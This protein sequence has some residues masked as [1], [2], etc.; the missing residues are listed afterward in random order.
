[1][2]KLLT[3]SV[4]LFLAAVT[5]LPAH[6]AP[7]SDLFSGGDLTQDKVI[8]ASTEPYVISKPI[9]V[10]KDV[11][12]TIEAGATLISN[13]PVTFEVAGNVRLIGTAENPV[14]IELGNNESIKSIGEYSS[15]IFE[16]V[17]LL[18]GQ[19]LQLARSAVSITDSEIAG[20]TGCGANSVTLGAGSKF[21]RNAFYRA[22]PFD[23]EANFGLFGPTGFGGDL[24][25]GTANIIQN[26]FVGD[27]NQGCWVNV[28]SLWKDSINLRGNEFRGVGTCAIGLGFFPT[29]VT[30]EN[31]FWGDYK[32]EKVKA[33]V[34]GSVGDFFTAP[35]IQLNS[36]APT[37]DPAAPAESILKAKLDSTPSFLSSRTAY[38]SDSRF[39]ELT[40]KFQPGALSE[41]LKNFEVGLFAL[42]AQGLDPNLDSS[43][44]PV[45]TLVTIPASE[46]MLTSE[47]LSGAASQA[48]FAKSE[49][50]AVRVR[51]NFSGWS[52]SWS[53]LVAIQASRLVSHAQ[54]ATELVQ[55]VETA[56]SL[57]YFDEAAVAVN[58][59][60]S[61][62]AKEELQARLEK[63]KSSAQAAALAKSVNAANLLAAK[64]KYKNCASLTKKLP[65]G[66][67][68]SATV[69]NKGAPLKKTPFVSANGYKL[70]SKLDRDKDG[71]VCES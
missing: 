39:S 18:G 71:I 6:A 54:V 5:G 4:A 35:L 31:N 56:Y 45:P 32:L 65:G 23:V 68:R 16:H 28:W 19:P 2:K 10:A 59:L 11:T 30:A 50:L 17:L 67:A 66:I 69:V 22:C 42:K 25:R 7:V 15:V 51:A 21:E 33:L 14:R 60:D 24:S 26:L 1:M 34:P 37:R 48:G 49:Y 46:F 8:A 9:R 47:I 55:R 12:L 29:T 61:S 38:P 43:Y 53:N 63:V 20:Q 40:F 62:G 41:G 36:L 70:N 44:F 3:L 13:T 58:A 57:N 52:S 64:V 27:A